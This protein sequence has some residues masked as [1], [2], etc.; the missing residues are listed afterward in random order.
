[1]ATPPHRSFDLAG[2]FSKDGCRPY[3]GARDATA[4]RHDVFAYGVRCAESSPLA[5]RCDDTL[6]GTGWETFQELLG[7]SATERQSPLT[8]QKEDSLS[9]SVEMPLLGMEARQ[10]AVQACEERLRHAQMAEVAVLTRL[11]ACMSSLLGA[12]AIH[13]HCSSGSDVRRPTLPA[14]ADGKLE[15]CRLRESSG[16]VKEAEAKESPPCSRAEGPR[17]DDERSAGPGASHE[18]QP[19]LLLPVFALLRNGDEGAASPSVRVEQ[20]HL[21]SAGVTHD[22]RR[23][24]DALQDL[25]AQHNIPQKHGEA[26]EGSGGRDQRHS[27]PAACIPSPPVG[28]L[29]FQLG[30]TSTRDADARVST[31]SKTCREEDDDVAGEFCCALQP[32]SPPENREAMGSSAARLGSCKMCTSPSSLP[33]KS[34]LGEALDRRTPSPLLSATQTATWSDIEDERVFFPTPPRM[35]CRTDKLTSRLHQ[36]ELGNAPLAIA[37]SAASA[38][39]LKCSES[40]ANI[41]DGT[42]TLSGNI[43][44]GPCVSAEESGASRALRRPKVSTAKS[45]PTSQVFNVL[46]LSGVLHTELS[47]SQTEASGASS[48]LDACAL[49][50]PRVALT[51]TDILATIAALPPP[52]PKSFG[53]RRAKGDK[54]AVK[55]RTDAPQSPKKA[56][57]GTGKRHREGDLG[58]M[59]LRECNSVGARA[60][61][62]EGLPC[63]GVDVDAAAAAAAQAYR[64]QRPPRYPA[65]LGS[66]ASTDIDGSTFPQRGSAGR[67]VAPSPPLCGYVRTRQQR[68]EDV[69]Q[70]EAIFQAVRRAAGGG[71]R[72]AQPCTHASSPQE[73]PPSFAGDEASI[74][75]C[76]SQASYDSLQNTPS[77]YWDID[78]P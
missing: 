5:T 40:S 77:Q 29:L 55:S 46:H 60:A 68:A 35:A 50:A 49:S 47:W 57:R 24:Y 59:D 30:H 56:P 54:T 14:D 6:H 3:R 74:T 62:L 43:A 9:R 20:L 65:G 45:L 41:S 75:P 69:A 12:S 39:C 27:S 13:R 25:I 23:V 33:L 22:A 44:I 4:L 7:S 71:A 76:A 61:P 19:S 66:G 17:K 38:T 16:L 53:S 63:L 31:P 2:P 73:Q 15:S 36:G 51:A 67:R 32:G 10:R 48:P 21:P 58:D 18:I 64:P 70:T 26:R 42:S 34:T 37:P 8:L 1:M 11:Y 52:P 78:F 28:A 72:D